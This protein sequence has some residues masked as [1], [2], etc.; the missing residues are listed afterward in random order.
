LLITIGASDA[1]AVIRPVS[2]RLLI[3]NFLQN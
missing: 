3:L 2:F 1:S